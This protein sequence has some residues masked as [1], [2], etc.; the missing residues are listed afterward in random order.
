MSPNGIFKK[1]SGTS[2]NKSRQFLIAHR[3]KLLKRKITQKYSYKYLL[4]E[5]FHKVILNRPLPWL[6]WMKR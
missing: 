1:F 3:Q 5:D 6:I 2:H 4:K